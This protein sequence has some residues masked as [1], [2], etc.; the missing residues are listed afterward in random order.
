MRTIKGAARNRAKRRLLRRAKGYRGGRS[1]L[2]RTAKETLL[3]AGTSPIAIDALENVSFASFGSFASTRPCV[4]ADCGIVSSFT[5]CRRPESNWIASH[6]RRSPSA[7]PPALIKS[8]SKSRKSWRLD[9]RHNRTDS[10]TSRRGNLAAR[11]FFTRPATHRF[12]PWSVRDGPVR[13]RA[14]A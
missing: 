9:V 3:R 14:A 6:C 8:S 4:N 5:D 11:W 7:T 10:T 2:L 12:C 13:F 1:N